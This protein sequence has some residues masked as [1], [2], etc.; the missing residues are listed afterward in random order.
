MSLPYEV[1]LWDWNGTLLND[2]E[3][4]RTIID[5]MLHSRGLPPRS[6][7]E[8]ARLFDFPV[9]RYYQRLGFDFQKEPFEILSQEFID[10]YYGEVKSCALQPGSRQLLEAIRGTGLRQSVLS[11]SRQDH[12]EDQVAFYELGGFFDEL[13]GIDTV[14]APGKSGR[15]CDWISESGLDPER[16]LLIGDTVH[17]AEVAEKMGTHCWLVN[18]GHNPEVRLRATGRP[19]FHNLAAVGEALM[20][21]SREGRTA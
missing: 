13:L 17:D 1:I 5:G 21:G 3:F 8:H 9:I 14:H 2:A 15:G 12:L 19:C 10:A 7:E 20:D 16:V 4:G 18:G 11:A 6:R